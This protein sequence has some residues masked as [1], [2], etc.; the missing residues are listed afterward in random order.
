M[1]KHSSI[2]H[3][4]AVVT[5][6]VALA[7]L[8]TLLFVTVQPTQAAGFTIT[9]DQNDEDLGA[10]TDQQQLFGGQVGIIEAG[11]ELKHSAESSPA[12]VVLNS[13]ND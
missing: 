8:I 7:L 1:R 12:I 5:C 3:F 6:S 11:G 13:S 2:K 10:E 4:K 9:S